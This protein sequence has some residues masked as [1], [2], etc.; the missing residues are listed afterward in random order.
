MKFCVLCLLP[1]NWNIPAVFPLPRCYSLEGIRGRSLI[2]YETNYKE[3]EKCLPLHSNM[4]FSGTPR[5]CN[6]VYTSPLVTP[7]HSF[8]V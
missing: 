8:K 6:G 3:S 7:G 4:R 5:L 2:F 1:H